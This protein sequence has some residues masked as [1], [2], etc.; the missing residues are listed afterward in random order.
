MHNIKFESD[1]QLNQENYVAL[2]ILAISWKLDEFFCDS[3]IYHIRICGERVSSK[4]ILIKTKYSFRSVIT[5]LP[6]VHLIEFSKIG[7][8]R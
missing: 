4:A 3:D 2:E 8:G 7:L 1:P 5:T 6:T